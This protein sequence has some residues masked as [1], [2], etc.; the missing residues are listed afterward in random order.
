MTL[1]QVDS[2]RLRSEAERIL[3]Q[4][5]Y[6]PEPTASER[7]REWL[8]DLWLR[9][10]EFLEWVADLVGGPAVFGFLLLTLV[11]VASILVARNLGSRRAREIEARIHREYTLARGADPAEME[12]A[13]ENAARDGDYGAAVRWRFR[14]GLLRLDERGR[15]RYQPGLTSSEVSQL[16]ISP[17][18]EILAR[19]FD[20]IVYGHQA[21][22]SVDDEQARQG[23]D[24][25]LAAAPSEVA[26][27]ARP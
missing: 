21:A 25:L 23:W 8:S 26:G 18:F 4:P 2:D 15:I 7:L 12:T 10:L 24:R 11:V 22:S 17:E 13:A 3:N 14:A 5:Q 19:R 20:E 27:G 16:L 6:R 9:F 1:L